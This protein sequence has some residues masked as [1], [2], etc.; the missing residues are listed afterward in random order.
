MWVFCVYCFWIFTVWSIIYCQHFFAKELCVCNQ[1]CPSL[2][3][4]RT[5]VSSCFERWK[6]KLSDWVSPFAL[7]VICFWNGRGFRV[8][9]FHCVITG[10]NNLS[11]DVRILIIF[12]CESLLHFKHYPDDNSSEMTCSNALWQT[13]VTALTRV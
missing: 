13:L 1:C 10:R 7:L 12:E 3:W 4:W 6:K 5:T 11:Y 9:R 2:L 8:D